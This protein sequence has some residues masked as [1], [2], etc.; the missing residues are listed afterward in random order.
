M[1]RPLYL[2]DASLYIFRAWFAVPEAVRD[3]SGACANAVHGFGSFLCDLIEYEGPSHVVCA[4]DESLTTSFR[5]E[6]YPDYKANR[7]PPPPELERQFDVCRELAEALG[8]AT[9]ASPRYEA[10]DL[11]GSAA[12]HWREA[13]YHMVFVT[14]DKDYAQLLEPGDWWWDAARDRWLDPAGVE[15]T[16]GVPPGRVADLLA[17]AG[18]AV[19]NIPG[20][21]GIGTKTAAALLARA[22]SLDDLYAD[23][24]QVAASGVRGARRVRGLLETHR[25]QAFLSRRLT[26]IR[27]DLPIAHAHEQ[28]GWSGADP[29]ALDAMALPVQLR[30]RTRRLPVADAMV[31]P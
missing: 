19:D 21:P 4:F 15:E 13:G 30:N 2:I 25:E 11:V 12:R 9:L 3:D 28:A 8:V 10:D 26:R 5:N 17:L 24:D 16:L 14:A 7:P 27:C 1:Y 31:A 6:L 18:D 23:L 29:S 20:V 22:G